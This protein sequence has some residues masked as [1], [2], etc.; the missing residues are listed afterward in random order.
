MRSNKL[1]DTAIRSRAPL[2]FLTSAL[3]VAGR[4]PTRAFATAFT[5][6]IPH[7]V[8]RSIRAGEVDVGAPSE[9]PFGVS[10]AGVAP[11]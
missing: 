1:I 8:G 5:G 4:P 2:D 11:E 10:V 3:S 7:I 6:I 9:V